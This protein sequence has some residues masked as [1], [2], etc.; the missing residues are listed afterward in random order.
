MNKLWCIH[1]TEYY[2]VIKRNELLIYATIWMNLKNAETFHIRIHTVITLKCSSILGK[3][4]YYLK[5][6]IVIASG[7]WD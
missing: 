7:V 1:T 4:V 5:K 3:L 6:G 2:P